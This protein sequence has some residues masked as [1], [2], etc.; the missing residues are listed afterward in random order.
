MSTNAVI[1]MIEPQGSIKASY[2]H[3]DGY[4]SHTGVILQFHYNTPET[5]AG[6]LAFGH[7]ST[8]AETPEKCRFYHR[9]RKECLR[10]ARFSDTDSLLASSTGLFV[11]LWNGKEW[12]I[13]D[14]K[15]FPHEKT[16]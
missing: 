14:Q 16:S 6:L 3:W 7:I 12:L 4:P 8:L 10:N 9:D 13:F 15:G 11:Y 2:L 1:G 5:V